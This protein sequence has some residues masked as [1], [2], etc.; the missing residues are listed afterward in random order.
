VSNQALS[1]KQAFQ[2][3][4]RFLEQYYQRVGGRGELSTVL[5]D[6]QIMA[7]GSPA[8]PAAWEDWLE[9]IQAVI[10]DTAR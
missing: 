10:E 8:D 3:M 4:S 6:I 7:D 9:A 1:A 5:S 2:A